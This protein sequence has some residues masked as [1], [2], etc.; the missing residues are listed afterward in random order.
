MMEPIA[1]SVSHVSKAFD[2]SAHGGAGTLKQMLVGLLG[3][4]KQAGTSQRFEAL[5]DV[6]FEVRRG[7]TVGIMGINGSGKSTVL[8][9][10]TGILKPDAGTIHVEGRISPLLELGA[11]FHP[12]FTGREN[13]YLNAS[14][15]GLNRSQIDAIFEAIV[16]FAEIR[17]FIDQ[18]VRTYS[19][20]MY[21][22]LAFAVAV[23]VDPDV[24]VVDEVL[25]VGDHLFKA[26]CKA[27]LAAFREAGKTI[28]IVAHDPKVLRGTCDRAIWLEKGVV[29]MAGPAEEVVAAYE[30]DGVSPASFT[31]GAPTGPAHVR[32]TAMTAPEVL[33]AGCPF[34][35]GF[36][37]EADEPGELQFTLTLRDE[38]GEV[39]HQGTFS[40]VRTVLSGERGRYR[41]DGVAPELKQG[42]Y[43]LVVMPRLNG[44]AQRAGQG[45][46]PITCKSEWTGPGALPL[47]G[48]WESLEPSVAQ[49]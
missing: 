23:H 1:I 8:K 11:G 6:S 39:R 30:R 42:G 37:W 47:K 25:A 41:F 32:V 16:E 49:R 7:E 10:I 3:R 40:E 38:T 45:R 44:R 14:I 13:V 27:R 20:G 46:R 18:P 36:E 43:Q 26:K 28:L 12:D 35:V 2:L 31:T 15:L 24:L 48:E 4:E 5:K 34:E 29:R 19:S 17:A 33:M 9:L 21:S 22:R